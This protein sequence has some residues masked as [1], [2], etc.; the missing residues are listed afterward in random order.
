MRASAASAGWQHVKTSAS[1]SSGIELTSSSSAGSASSRASSSALRANVCSRRSRS[2]ARLR[3]VVTIHAPGFAGSPSR[4]Q[5]SSAIVKASCTAS[6]ASWM[7]PR[8][9][10]R[11]ATAR[12]HSSRKTRASEVSARSPVAARRTRGSDRDARGDRDRRVEVV[13]VRAPSAP[14]ICS[15]VS[16]KGPSVTIVSPS[17]TRT[18]FAVLAARRARRRSR[19][20]RS[21]CVSLEERLPLRDLLGAGG[22]RLLRAHLLPGLDVL[23]RCWSSSATYFMTPP[24]SRS[25][26]DRRRSAA[27]RSR[28]DARRGSSPPSAGLVDRLALEDVVAAERLLQLG[29]RAVRDERLVA[30]DAHRRRGRD[31]VELVAADGTSCLARGRCTRPARAPARSG[32]RSAHAALLAVDQCQ[33]LHPSSSWDLDFTT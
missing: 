20:R 10:V 16:A 31:R 9:R 11:M 21:A 17:R 30:A 5:R 28:R 33:V 19:A 27:P 8:T 6:S 2:I 14:P 1:R 22:L 18:V 7:S 32:D 25:R 29:E 3:A 12:P 15:F 4:C 23:G 24:P 26:S 13:G